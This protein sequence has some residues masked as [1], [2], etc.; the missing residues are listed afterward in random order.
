MA[1]KIIVDDLFEDIDFT[2]DPAYVFGCND[3]SPYGA[4]NYSTFEDSFRILTQDELRTEAERSAEEGG[5]E[6]LVTRVF[7]QRREGSCVSQACGQAAQL[8]QATQFGKDHVVQLSAMSLYKQIG[9]SARSG[10]TVSSGLRKLSEIGMLPLDTAKNRERYGSQVMENIGFD[11]KYP[12]GWKETAKHFQALEYSVLRS[13]DGILTALTRRQPVVVGRQGHSICYTTPIWSKNQWKFLYA[14]S[15]GERG[16]QAA[17]DF[18]GG[19]GIDTISQ[20]R[21]SAGWAFT[22][23]AVRGRSECPKKR[24]ETGQR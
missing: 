22:V 1:G 2:Q 6:Q 10:A 21:K 8:V 17:G 3:E 23:R 19:F 9:R 24:D 20:I 16:G 15:W 18:R 11:N 4:S 5:L 12:A 7:D 13:V 14:N